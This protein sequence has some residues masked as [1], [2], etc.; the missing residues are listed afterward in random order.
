M[1]L[2]GSENLDT[3]LETSEGYAH[4]QSRAHAQEKH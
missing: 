3:L 1:F 4:L 2:G